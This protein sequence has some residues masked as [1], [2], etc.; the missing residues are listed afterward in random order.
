MKVGEKLF[1][2]LAKLI[3]DRFYGSVTIRF[4]SGK[5]THVETETRRAWQYKDLPTQMSDRPDTLNGIE[6]AS[7]VDSQDHDQQVRGKR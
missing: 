3:L 5:V 6:S 7:T 2:F 4:E 1:H